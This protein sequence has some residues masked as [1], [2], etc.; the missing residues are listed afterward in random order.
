MKNNTKDFLDNRAP[1]FVISVIEGLEIIILNTV[2]LVTSCKIKKEV[3]N[4]LHIFYTFLGVSDLLNGYLSLVSSFTYFYKDLALFHNYKMC[5]SITIVTSTQM[6]ITGY[7]LLLLT[8]VKCCSI[9]IPLKCLKY[10]TRQMAISLST[11]VWIFT[12]CLVIIPS[13]VWTQNQVYS[14]EQ[15]CDLNTVY[16]DK[17]EHFLTLRKSAMGIFIFSLVILNSMIAI[18]IIKRRRNE[19]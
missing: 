2:L 14:S 3:R 4:Q 7:L 8:F 13:L 6:F 11:G 16:G 18:T 5:Y 19:F 12:S 1:I 10:V 15:E 17:I 9:L